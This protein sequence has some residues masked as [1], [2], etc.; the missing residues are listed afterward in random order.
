MYKR[1]LVALDGSDTS[2]LALE[3]AVQ[4]A[5][6][7][8]SR[9]RII[10]VVEEMAYAASYD[11]LAGYT[12]DVIEIL[13]QNGAK[14]LQEGIALG[15]AAGVETDQQLYDTMGQRLAE[16]VADAASEWQ[17]DLIVVGTH[18]RHGM[19][20]V[21]MGSGAE[22]IIRLAPVPVLVV[23]SGGPPRATRPPASP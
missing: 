23:R 9:L 16:T 1:I 5:K 10:H 22:Q 12:V 3:S 7:L 4:L 15:K 20:R 21:V 19:G 11:S 13:R 6:D 14:L 2:R 8:G 17:A 18:G